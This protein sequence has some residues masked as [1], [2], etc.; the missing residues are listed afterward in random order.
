VAW[1]SNPADAVATEH[2]V[3]RV[4]ISRE[5]GQ[6]RRRRNAWTASG[7]APACLP[8]DRSRWT[9]GA[10]ITFDA[11]SLC[12][13]R[14]AVGSAAERVKPPMPWDMTSNSAPPNCRIV[15]NTESLTA[16]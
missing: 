4:V 14:T 1:A 9:I 13:E 5:S 11:D 6:G 12:Y 15:S 8:A 2:V 3:T 16:P 7:W 10:Y